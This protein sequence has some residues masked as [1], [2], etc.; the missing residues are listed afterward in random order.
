MKIPLERFLSSG[1]RLQI[2]NVSRIVTL[3]DETLEAL[4]DNDLLSQAAVP[5]SCL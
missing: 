4:F 5:G 2:L 1:D 3:Y